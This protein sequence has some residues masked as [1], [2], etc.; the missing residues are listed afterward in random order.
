MLGILGERA[1]TMKM[2][3]FKSSTERFPLFAG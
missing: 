1:V 2:A 3:A